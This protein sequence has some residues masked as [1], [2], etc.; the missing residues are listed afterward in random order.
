MNVA[1][2][3]GSVGRGTIPLMPQAESIIVTHHAAASRFEALV[4]GRLCECCY[5][6][7]GT[8]LT[9]TH[10]EVPPS[11]AGRGIAAALVKAALE[12]AQAQGVQVVPACSYVAAYMQRHP[13]TQALLRR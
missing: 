10:T 9:F 1:E 6:L 7:N 13:Q 2:V 12:W 11:L 5:L 3:L 8:V 4:E